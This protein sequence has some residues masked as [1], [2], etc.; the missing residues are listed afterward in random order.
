M[1]TPVPSKAELRASALA[2]RAAIA[3]QAHGPASQAAVARLR[4]LL[5]RGDTVSL[6]WP[7]RGEIDPRDLV[8]D[9]ERAGGRV[10]LPAVLAGRMIFR[11]YAGEAHLEDG[12][13]GTRHPK[14]EEPD[15]DPDLIVAPLAAFDR[16][17]GRI[18]YGAGHYD[19][20]IAV[21]RASGRRPRIA[22]IAFACQE[23]E[24]VPAEPHDVRLD[25][26]ATEHELIKVEA[27]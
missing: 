2:R 27:A 22:G 19:R 23:V 14:A 1:L 11:R 25:M 10:A 9:I 3:E 18:G 15:L 4:T 26:I 6:Y 5:H 21:I 17:G 7:M 20:A 8:D 24:H 13:F 12:P 16:R